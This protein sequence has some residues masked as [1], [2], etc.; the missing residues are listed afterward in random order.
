MDYR[1]VALIYDFDKT[2]SPIDMQEFHYIGKLGYKETGSFWAES[3]RDKYASNM[4]G[5]LSYM[6]LMVKKNPA[7]TK[8]EL[9]DEGAFIEL[10]KGVDTWFDR[11]NEYGR[12]QGIEVEHF[13]V[14]S[15]IREMIMGTSIADKFKR[16]YACSYTY[17]END[18]PVWPSRVVNYTTKTQYLFRINK[19][20]FD[21]T[22]DLD[23]NT[24]TPEEDKYVP[25]SNMVYF[26]DGLTDVPSML[27]MREEGGS[28]VAV[29]GSKQAKEKIAKELQDEKR[30]DY[31]L[32]ADYSEG[33][34]AEELVKAIIDSVAVNI[35]L[36]ELKNNG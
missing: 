14:S 15:G 12:K 22:N 19:G 26:G 8:K 11:V 18:K 13:I 25:F 31:M 16:V 7:L 32:P 4:D 20:V 27:V 34:A 36:R 21:E 6:H 33:S 23:L 17:D 2:L 28:A 24:K 1:K 35:R 30:A 29:Y 3:E 5:I 10:Y 9:V